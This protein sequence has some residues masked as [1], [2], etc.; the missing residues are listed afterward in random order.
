MSPSVCGI[1]DVAHSVFM[2]SLCNGNVSVRLSKKVCF[3]QCL[4]SELLI[5]S[6]MLISP[7]ASSCYSLWIQITWGFANAQKHLV[8]RSE[9]VR[10][11]VLLNH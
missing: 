9:G 3:S 8:W 2:L 1:T 6:P 11:L 5:R 7:T 10:G 4:G